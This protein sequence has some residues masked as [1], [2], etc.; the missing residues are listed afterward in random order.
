MY[1]QNPIST[2]RVINNSLTNSSDL[3]YELVRLLVFD[4]LFVD[5]LTISNS[6]Q[7]IMT[8]IYID[9]A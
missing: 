8:Y 1:I 4:T 9:T 7:E 3:E 5:N 6:H 2:L